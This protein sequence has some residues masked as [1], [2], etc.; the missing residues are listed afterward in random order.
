MSS[1]SP[2][3]DLTL[4]VINFAS[5]K[6]ITKKVSVKKIKVSK[7]ADTTIPNKKLSLPRK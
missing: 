4:I 7:V 6:S 3:V 5:K 1:S 2:G